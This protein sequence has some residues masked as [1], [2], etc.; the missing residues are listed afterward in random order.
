MIC[1]DF[2]LDVFNPFG[3]MTG[4]LTLGDLRRTWGFV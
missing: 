1:S 2:V 4:S 3:Y